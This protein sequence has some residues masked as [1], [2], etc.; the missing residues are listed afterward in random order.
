M[1]LTLLILAVWHML[2]GVVGNLLHEKLEFMA[3]LTKKFTTDSY[4]AEK[5]ESNV[6][7]SEVCILIKD[8]CCPVFVTRSHVSSDKKQQLFSIQYLV[9]P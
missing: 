7:R 5:F 2:Y 4:M 8:F 1:F 9:L 6:A 3:R